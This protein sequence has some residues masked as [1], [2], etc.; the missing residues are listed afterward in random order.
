MSETVMLR[1]VDGSKTDGRDQA[2]KAPKRKRETSALISVTSD[3]KESQIKAL[4][5]EVQGL[6]RFYREML[7]EKP[8]LESVSSTSRILA[9]MEEKSLPFEKLVEEIHGKVKEK[10]EMENVTMAMVRSAVLSSG[11]RVM[12]GVPNAD[13]DILN[14]DTESCLWC[15]ETTDLKLLPNSARGVLKIRRAC[16]KKIRERI[17]AVS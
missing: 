11:R 2:K 3:Q 17:V 9:L 15:W 5:E 1:D 4:N 7:D 8:V 10:E 14:D 12:Y 13:A 16:R 6:F